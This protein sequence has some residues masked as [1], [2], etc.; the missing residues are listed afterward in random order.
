MQDESE[1][2]AGNPSNKFIIQTRNKERRLYA[3]FDID[4][5]EIEGKRTY[6]IEQK[7]RQN[8]YKGD[9]LQFMKGEDFT[10][11]YMQENGLK[12]PILFKDKKGLGMR[13]PSE[14]FKVSDVKQC[15]GSRRVLDVMDVTTQKAME[16]TMKE[17]VAYYENPQRDRLLNVIS[18]EF[19]HTRLENYVESPTLVR[20]IDWVDQ[21]WPR[22]L[23]DCQKESTNV[24]EKMMY[25]KV[26][27][28]CLM[29]VAGCYTDFHIDF[30]GTSVWYN[31]L[32][33]EKIFWLIP[34]T[35]ENIETY[36][37]WVL[38]AKQGDVFLPDEVEDCQKVTLKAGDTLIIPS[39]WIHAVFT[40]KDSLVFGGNFLHS[41][42]IPEQLKVFEVEEKTHVP[43]KFRYPF[44]LEIMWYVLA[45][46][47]CCVTGKAYVKVP[48]N[49]DQDDWAHS[50]ASM[51]TSDESRPPSQNSNSRPSSRNQD[52]II[53]FKTEIGETLIKNVKVALKRL[54]DSLIKSY[55]DEELQAKPKRLSKKSS[56]RDTKSDKKTTNDSD[57]SDKKWVH[58]TK[59]ELE[60][61]IQL[62][63]K[64]QTFPL[65]KRG[66]PKDLSD[67]DGLLVDIKQMLRDH[68]NDN[69]EFAITGEPSC[70]MPE[71]QKKTKSRTM[72][73]PKVK[74]QK[75]SFSGGPKR[76]RVRCKKCEPCTR[77]EC[78]E[79][80][81]CKDMKKFGGPGR[82]KQ[83]C[84]SRQCM[85]PLLPSTAVCDICHGDEL[86][87]DEETGDRVSTLMECGICWSIVHPP[88][89]AEKNPE[90]HSEGNINEDSPNTWMCSKC[91]QD[92]K[93]AQFRMR[94]YP[95][96]IPKTVG[97]QRESTDGDDVK[98]KS[99]VPKT[100]AIDVKAVEGKRVVCKE[101]P[102]VLEPETDLTD[103]LQSE[104]SEPPL[105]TLE[106][107]SPNLDL[108]SHLV[109]QDK[110]RERT[111][112]KVLKRKAKQLLEQLPKQT[113][114]RNKLKKMKRIHSVRRGPMLKATLSVYGE[115]EAVHIPRGRS[116]RNV[117]NSYSSSSDDEDDSIEDVAPTII[118]MSSPRKVT[119]V[120]DENDGD[121]ARK[122]P[123]REG[124][125][126]GRQG[127]GVER[128][129]IPNNRPTLRPRLGNSISLPNT[130]PRRKRTLTEPEDGGT[131]K[132]PK[133]SKGRGL[134]GQDRPRDQ[135]RNPD[136]TSRDKS[137]SFPSRPQRGDG[138]NPGQGGN[139]KEMGDKEQHVVRPAPI[140]PP[141]DE[142]LMPN[143][144]K[145]P[146]N[147]A[148][149]MKIF[150]YLQPSDLARCLCVCQTWN[151]WV[152]DRSLWKKIVLSKKKIVQEILAGVVR[153]Q[154]EVLLLNQSRMT[155]KQL[156]WLL[157][158]LPQLRELDLSYL[159][160]ATIGA[161]CS[162]SCPLLRSLTLNWACGIYEKCFTDLI[163]PPVDRLPAV[164]DVSRLHLLTNLSIAGTEATDHTLDLITR[165]IPQIK[166][167]NLSYCMRITDKGVEILFGQTSPLKA[168]LKEIDVSRC[169]QLT[170]QV[171]SALKKGAALEFINFRAC[172]KISQQ[173][174][175]KFAAAYI[176]RPMT[177]L[178]D[179]MIIASQ[180][181]SQN[182]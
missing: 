47:L 117:V 143:G 45:R 96:G 57:G 127:R 175:Q 83:T 86:V 7:L 32:H 51:I 29:S 85:A 140:P 138:D 110:L 2:K 22:Y 39:G 3:D 76:R 18:L 130:R 73:T 36:Q 106:E 34:P 120:S 167:L 21:V 4:D 88:C 24:I 116:A 31:I 162:C 43:H 172:E 19:C 1:T 155:I 114:Q 69:P 102:P 154:P 156:S 180:T 158:R 131:G 178:A 72:K 41:F 111:I 132:N 74:S 12:N 139:G 129:S 115:E 145:H 118:K 27:K 144:K 5:D 169:V 49:Y 134:P 103:D 171:F 105:L 6:N 153:R 95:G 107:I 64:V 54:D 82:M 25:P 174:C 109:K 62:V 68:M 177:V 101:M 16:M 28:Y 94:T 128:P 44:Y 151:R 125:F 160:W 113:S 124:P 33:G 152:I 67:P 80:N 170:D 179:K 168:T 77:T 135:G 122:R 23:I 166:K 90:L 42:N 59:W 141:P 159:S 75:A 93:E 79:C 142:V 173:S 137:E 121:V 11:K 146:L 78:G 58:L 181:S 35:D 40:P 46:Y 53:N 147:R 161:L 84:I 66:V 37:N 157:A 71:S 91:C 63:G 13:I 60:G 136:K 50:P 65:H 176:F 9:Y 148:M 61:L 48:E 97:N 149:W 30:G 8:T 26:K 126:P 38:S 164:N 99:K 52:D 87:K 15:V 112:K 182:M 89:L 133:S 56:S 163:L 10:L 17:W 108:D 55:G 150:Y 123:R 100:I 14:N 165:H 70:W 92:G 119:T 20:Q 81:F 98:V 104:I